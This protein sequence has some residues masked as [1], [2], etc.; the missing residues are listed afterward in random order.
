MAG[1]SGREGLGCIAIVAVRLAIVFISRPRHSYAM[2]FRGAK[3][4]LFLGR[5]L[6]VI[7]RDDFPDIPYPGHW[8]L[9]GGGREGGE[10]PAQ[11]ALRETHEEIGLQLREQDLAWS[12]EY[13]R[14]SGQMWF[15]V[16]HQP[17]SM[18]EQIH[19]GSEG[20]YWKLMSPAEY[21]AHPLA[22]PHFTDQVNDYLRETGN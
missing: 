6:V 4:A 5:D 22:V 16:M 9:P 12:R 18:A 17:R 1:F 11:C 19:F 21:C 8:D 14:P 15:F 20:Q 10:T 2:T 13:S 7:L 3:L